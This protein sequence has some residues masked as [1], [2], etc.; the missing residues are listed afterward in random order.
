MISPKAVQVVDTVLGLING[1]IYFTQQSQRP[2]QNNY[3]L[4]VQSHWQA[5]R[6]PEHGG[7]KPQMANLPRGR[8]RIG[9]STCSCQVPGR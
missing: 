2:S 5:N 4:P 3:N 7:D 6:S 9:S 8:A 1:L